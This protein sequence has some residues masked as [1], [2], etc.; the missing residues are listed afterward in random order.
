MA[1][2]SCALSW[3]TIFRVVRRFERLVLMY[4]L[5][6]LSVVRVVQ[7]GISFLAIFM[8]YALFGMVIF[9]KVNYF[10]SLMKTTSTLVSLMAGDSIDLISSAISLKYNFILANLYIFTYVILFMQTIYNILTSI[11]NDSYLIKKKEIDKQRKI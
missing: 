7:F 5:I 8:G 10:S 2:L 3:M 11:I 9:R 6:K 4:N 1:G